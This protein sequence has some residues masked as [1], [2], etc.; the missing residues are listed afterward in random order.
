MTIHS[1]CLF[2]YPDTLVFPK[3]SQTIVVGTSA[4][5]NH[6]EKMFAGYQKDFLIGS[7]KTSAVD[8]VRT[9]DAEVVILSLLC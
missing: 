7:L 6:L 1:F 3:T 9:M 2:S 5:K 8:A 4:E